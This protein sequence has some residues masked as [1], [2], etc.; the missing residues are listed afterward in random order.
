MSRQTAVVVTSIA[1]PNDIL[2]S[3]A[4]GTQRSGWTFYIIGDVSSPSD[5]SLPGA[6]FLNVQ[7]Q[8]DTGFATA[9]A[10]PTR[11]YAR[12][13]IGYLL[14]MRGGVPANRYFGGSLVSVQ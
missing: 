4:D 2:I 7:E 1:S 11:H 12:K 8:I 3:L 13:N 6:Q 5:F 9:K 10:C 14:A